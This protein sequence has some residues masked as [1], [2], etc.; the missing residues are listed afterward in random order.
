MVSAPKLVVV[1]N[2]FRIVGP[3]PIVGFLTAHRFGIP[4]QA[5][6]QHGQRMVPSVV[7]T[8]NSHCH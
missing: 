6:A 3:D 2:R 4:T 1:P 5:Q 7:I 8:K